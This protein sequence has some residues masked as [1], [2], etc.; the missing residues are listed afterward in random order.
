MSRTIRTNKYG[1]TKTDKFKKNFNGC[2]CAYCEY[3]NHDFRLDH[4][5]RESDLD[6]KRTVSEITTLEEESLSDLAEEDYYLN[7]LSDLILNENNDETVYR[8]LRREN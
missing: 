8:L 6:I 7:E 1:E 4:K 2:G 5:V 3:V